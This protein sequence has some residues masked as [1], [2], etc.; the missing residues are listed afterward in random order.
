MAWFGRFVQPAEHSRFYHAGASEFNRRRQR[1]QASDQLSKRG[2]RLIWPTE[3][4]I[5]VTTG[6][7]PLCWYRLVANQPQPVN[8]SSSVSVWSEVSDELQIP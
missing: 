7:R 1:I 2:Q 8:L 6:D 5:E 3:G 4:V